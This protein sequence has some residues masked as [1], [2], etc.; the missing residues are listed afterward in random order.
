MHDGQLATATLSTSEDMTMKGMK[1]LFATG[2]VLLLAPVS[3]GAQ[4]CGWILWAIVTDYK[5]VDAPQYWK[6][7][8]GAPSYETCT[9]L[10]DVRTRQYLRDEE[11]KMSRMKPGV[12]LVEQGGYTDYEFVC[13]PTSFKPPSR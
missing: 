7:V 8:E 4:G 9:N 3:V 5:K 10:R 12:P 6:V 11:L 1:W 2:L 13:F